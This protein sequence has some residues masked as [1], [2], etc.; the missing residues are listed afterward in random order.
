MRAS[1][2]LLED[3]IDEESIVTAFISALE[4]LERKEHERHHTYGEKRLLTANIARHIRRFS[5]LI[6]EE[7]N[8][9]MIDWVRVNISAGAPAT[10]VFQ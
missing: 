6:D 5:K 7:F 2:Y 10:Y 1:T 9:Q 4:V 8:E 3:N